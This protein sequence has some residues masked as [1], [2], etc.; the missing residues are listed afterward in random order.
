[1]IKIHLSK[2]YDGWKCVSIPDN[3]EMIVR[4]G[5]EANE[6]DASLRDLLEVY[7]MVVTEQ[8]GTIIIG[9]GD[10][11]KLK[12]NNDEL[13][14]YVSPF[15]T[16]TDFDSV[17]HELEPLL[18]DVFQAHDEKGDQE[19]RSEMLSACQSYLDRKDIELDV[20]AVYRELTE[21]DA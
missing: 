21:T 12:A 1:M 16:D 13:Q 15:T 10:V 17:R 3:I 19:R 11:V 9:T 14:L 5:E 8:Y 18:A 7:G 20:S 6:I 4:M 2:V